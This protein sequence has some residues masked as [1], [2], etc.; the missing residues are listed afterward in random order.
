MRWPWIYQYCTSRII[1]YVSWID[2]CIDHVFIG[3][4]IIIG[5]QHCLRESS[6]GSR[7][8]ENCK[9]QD[10][11]HFVSLTG[12]APAI[13]IIYD[14]Y[15]QI[16][17]LFLQMWCPYAYIDDFYAF[18][19]DLSH[20]MLTTAPV[21]NASRFRLLK[22]LYLHNNAILRVPA[23]SSSSSQSN[24]FGNLA[25]ITFEVNESSIRV[26]FSS[27]FIYCRW[28]QLIFE[29]WKKPYVLARFWMQY[30]W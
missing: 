29:L 15:L 23:S 20:N 9:A 18:G 27:L 2:V 1:Y 30:I 6:I 7:Y 10:Y 22:T 13:A 17:A 21:F 25:S 16:I 19:R 4:W 5:S 3:A 26:Y 14:A 24:L 11:D 8:L 28:G 12:Q